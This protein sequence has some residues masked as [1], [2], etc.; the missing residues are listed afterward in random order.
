[1]QNFNYYLPTK[2]LHGE[3]IVLQNSQEF[4]RYGKKALIVTGKNSAKQSGALSNV[5]TAFEQIE[6]E[7]LLFDQVENNPSLENVTLGGEIARRWNPDFILGI[8]GGSPLD[9]AKAIAVLATNAIPA[10]DLFKNTYA[11]QPLPIL[12]IPTTAGTGSE[13]TPYSVLT[14]PEAE[15]KKGFGGA[16]LFPKVAF[17]DNQYTASLPL[18]VTVDTAV[19]ALSHLV[20]AYLSRRASDASDLFAGQGIQLWKNCIAPLQAGE[21]S[22]DVRDA[23]LIA[24]TLGGIAISHTGTTFVH[25]LGYP[26]TYYHGIPHGQANGLIMGEF[27]RYTHTVAPNR[28]NNVLQWIELP[29]VDS[30]L[31]LMQGFFRNKLQ[32]TADQV[33]AYALTASQTKN[34]GYS[35]G[36]V[37]AEVCDQVLSSSFLKG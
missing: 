31:H 23:L 20:E 7:Y 13:A 12:A 35:L 36:N 21:L 8:G 16:A 27:L 24:S 34:A 30:F 18:A 22:A 33:K 5:L 19:D 2:I 6:M 9:A 10:I 11:N 29:D 15:T 32:L 4:A 17:L 37:T 1:M 25:A 14:I 28:V 3:G 26:L